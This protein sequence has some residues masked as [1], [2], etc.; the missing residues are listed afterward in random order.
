MVYRHETERRSATT[1]LNVDDN[2]ATRYA[3][4]RLLK[5]AGFEVIE[6]ETGAAA[7]RI[8]G[9]RSPQL[10]LMDVRLPDMS[11]IDVTRHIKADPASMR[12]PVVQISATFVTE[13]DRLTG[14]DGG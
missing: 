7:L 5:Q 1:I 11:G 2:S 4:S 12:T 3:R 10:V 13:Q 6:A 8:M 9:E 14:L